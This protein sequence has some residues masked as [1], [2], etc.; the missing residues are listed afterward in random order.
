V[1]LFGSP[2]ALTDRLDLALAPRVGFGILR[3][4]RGGDVF[5]RLALGAH[6]EEQLRDA[7]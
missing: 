6:S 3:G 7:A 2:V 1:L 5:Q 4:E